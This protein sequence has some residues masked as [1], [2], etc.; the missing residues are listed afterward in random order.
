MVMCLTFCLAAV[1]QGDAGPKH[2]DMASPR[3]DLH[4]RWSFH[5]PA[6][7]VWDVIADPRMSWPDWWAQCAADEPVGGPVAEPADAT[8]DGGGLVG[9]NA[10]LAFRAAPGYTLHL[11]IRPTRVQAPRFVEFDAEGDLRGLGRV[12]LVEDGDRT[13]VH[14]QWIVRPARRWM[15]LLSPIAAPVF[16]AM[17]ARVMRQGE[18]GLREFLA[19]PDG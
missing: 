4:T 3:Y 5:A 17:H 18:R 12:A 15:A 6:Q 9:R 14:I 1:C 13:A 11:T 10:S 19:A 8:S 7:R 16:S 2:W